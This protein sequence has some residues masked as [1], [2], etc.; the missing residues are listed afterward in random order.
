MLYG[1]EKEVGL[2]RYLIT[3][4]I[5]FVKSSNSV[6]LNY[7]EQNPEAHS[8]SILHY[9]KTSP[10]LK[11]KKSKRLYNRAFKNIT[12]NWQ[13]ELIHAQCSANA[14]IYAHFI[15]K[16]NNLPFVI[17]EH[18][19]FLLNHYNIKVQ[20]GIKKAMENAY[21]VG[22]VSYHQKRCILMNG[23]DCN[24]EIIWNLM[25][26]NKFKIAVNN[27]DKKFTI[28]TIT[29]PGLIKDSETFFK[30]LEL[31]QTICKSDFEAVIIGNDSFSDISKANSSHF[32]LLAKK[33]NVYDKCLFL[34]QLSRKEINTKLQACDVFIS[35]SVAET[36]GVAVREAMLCGKPIIVTKSG[37]V[38]DSITSDTGIL[39]NLKDAQ[40]I[41]ENLLKIKNKEHSYNPEKIR[42][43][44][45]NQS[46][47]A[48][49]IKT[50][51]R[52]YN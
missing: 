34:P 42:A 32:E 16:T 18:Q 22:A 9:K 21:K 31:F 7:L 14:G 36:Y 33:H 26:E 29:Y 13:P 5:S 48:A 35:T 41:A 50:M 12:T 23:I 4:F 10:K 28:T 47:T 40:S 44:I 24:P 39:V 17:I 19:V 37:G 25:D 38:E 2:F 11:L 52:F 30:S 51:T 46:G 1:V 49:F 45:I 20:K 15:S 6:N 3:S 43:H 27:T 8:F